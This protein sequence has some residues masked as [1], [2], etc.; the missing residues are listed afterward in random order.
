AHRGV[1]EDERD[2]ADEQQ[3]QA[4]GGEH[5]VDDAAVEEAH[6]EPLDDKPD[7]ADH[8]RRHHQH[9]DIDVD[10]GLGAGDG[11]IA[12]EHDELAMGEIDH[13]HHAEDDRQPGADE[14]EEGDHVDDLE[15]DDRGVIHSCF[16]HHGPA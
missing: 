12:A 15:K 14:R 11:R 9:G 2:Q 3:A 1:A 13:A 4:P 16:H 8:D 7:D 5:G 6:D 10:A